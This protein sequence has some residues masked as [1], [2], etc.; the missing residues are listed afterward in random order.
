MAIIGAYRAIQEDRKLIITLFDNGGYKSIGALS[1][2][3]G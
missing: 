2:S 3:L 1:R